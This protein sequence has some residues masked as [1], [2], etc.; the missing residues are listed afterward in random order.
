MP[1]FIGGDGF[2]CSSAVLVLKMLANSSSAGLVR[3]V[4]SQACESG[5]MACCK[6]CAMLVI[7]EGLIL[8]EFFHDALINFISERDYRCRFWW[9]RGWW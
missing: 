2:Y 4:D 3:L 7:M 9:I 5:G 8:F 1:C 6:S